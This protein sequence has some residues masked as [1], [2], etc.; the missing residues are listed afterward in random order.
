MPSGAKISGI[1]SGLL[2]RAFAGEAAEDDKQTVASASSD[3]KLFKER[4]NKVRTTLY[5]GR[6]Y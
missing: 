4:I 2:V 6:I 3:A 1:V 5:V